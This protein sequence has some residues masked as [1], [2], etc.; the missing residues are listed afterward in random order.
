M[1]IRARVR[2]QGFTL[3]ELLVVIAI[4]AIL[5][6]LLLPALVNAKERARRAACKN[7][8]RQFALAIHMYGNDNAEKIPSG[9]SENE[10]EQD[11]HIPVISRDTRATILK[12]SGSEKIF[13]C[14]SLGKPFGK[15]EGWYFDLYGVVLGYNYLGG[16]RNTPWNPLAGGGK[17]TWISPQSLSDSSSLVLLADLNDWSPAYDKTFAPHGPRGPV[18][19]S[20]SD[21]SNEKASGVSSKVIGAAGGNVTLLDGSVTWKRIEEMKDYRGSR[22]WDEDGCYASW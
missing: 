12:Y 3:I 19:K 6:A 9:L 13:E 2:W 8:L 14:P 22:I 21:Y 16:H 15:K 7:H 4:I 20:G 17:A 10:N 11:E 18:L 1:G 5:A